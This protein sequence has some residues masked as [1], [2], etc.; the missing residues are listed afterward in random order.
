MGCTN[1][2]FYIKQHNEREDIVM[3]N[4]PTARMRAFQR[5]KG[6]SNENSVQAFV[7]AVLLVITPIIIWDYVSAQR[8]L[9]AAR[10]EYN[11][12]VEAE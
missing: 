12:M 1:P 5:R 9:T 4:Q 11:L 3:Y 8:D 7:I 2:L 6:I 10:V